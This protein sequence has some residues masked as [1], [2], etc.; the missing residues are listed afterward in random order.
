M[1]H[2]P[3]SSLRFL[4]ALAPLFCLSV[5]QAAA[6]G[7]TIART[8]GKSVFYDNS[9]SG[10][11]QLVPTATD[12]YS[13][14]EIFICGYAFYV[15]AAVN[16]GL[17]YGTD[18]ACATGTTKITPVYELTTTLPSIVDGA[19]SFRGLVVPAGQNLCINTS[20]AVAV[21]AIIYYD[22]SPL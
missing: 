1:M 16:V 15:A 19:N 7:T 21:Q 20:G 12:R 11:T 8:C 13:G 6:Q 2:P 18:L 3:L 4:L 9:T 22:N 17:V 5:G 10:A 14:N